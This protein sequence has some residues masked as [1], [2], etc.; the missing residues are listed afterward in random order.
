MD[1]DS[2]DNDGIK[3]ELAPRSVT[4]AYITVPALSATSITRRLVS[5]IPSATTH[6]HHHRERY[7]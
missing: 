4:S 5:A 2:C 7:T 3:I 1:R 6:H